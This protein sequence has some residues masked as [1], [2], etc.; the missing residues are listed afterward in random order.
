MNI[1]GCEKKRGIDPILMIVG[2]WVEILLTK[3]KE[4]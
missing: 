3:T 1:I 2:S 4:S